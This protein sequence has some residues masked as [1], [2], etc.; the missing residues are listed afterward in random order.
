MVGASRRNRVFPKK[1][2]PLLSLLTSVQNLFVSLAKR[3]PGPARAILHFVKS[4]VL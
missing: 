3:L 1:L 4:F 2:L